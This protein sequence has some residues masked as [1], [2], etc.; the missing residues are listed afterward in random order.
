MIKNFEPRLYQ[1]TIFATATA[2]NTLVVLPTGM[3]KSI[4][5]T[6]LAAHRL[7]QYP[8][9]QILILAPTKPLAEQHI[10]TLRGFLQVAPEKIS[11][12]TGEIAPEKRK[13]L[14][15][16]STI[17]VSTPQGLE[18]D[19]VARRIDLENVSLL[20]IDECH[21]AVGDYAYVWVA[22]RYHEL[23][24]YP[25]I[26]GLTASPGDD[27]E[28]IDEV[29][30]NLFIENIELRTDEDADVS[31]YIQE[32]ST[33]WIKVELPESM[34]QV[35]SDLKTML[36]V[37]FEKLKSWGVVKRADVSYVS[38]TDILSLSSE[39]RGRA[40]RGEK[41]YVLWNALSVLAETLKIFH[42]LELIES[43][44]IAAL[45]DYVDRLNTEGA[46]TKVKAVKSIV[47]DPVFRQIYARIRL[48]KESNVVH[49][50]LLEIERI[51][52][53]EIAQD[54]KTK[55]IVFN[56]YRDSGKEIVTMINKIE[57]ASARQFVGQA[58]K[59]E[60]GLSQKKQ[61]V[62]LDDFRE[63]KFNVLVATS[64]GE[65]GID[66]PKVDVVVFYEPVPSAIRTVQRR[67]RTGRL[68]K[69]KL[70]VLITKDTRDEGIRWAAHHKEKRMH[71]LLKSFKLDKQDI[72]P[73]PEKLTSYI[74]QDKLIVYADHREK[75]SGVIK[76]LIELGVKIELDQLE[77]ADYVISKRVGIELKTVEDF[78]ASLI[79]GR[80]L[81]QL[82]HLRRS[83]QRPVI[84]I[85]GEEDLYSVRNVHKNALR[86][87]LATIAVSYGIPIV[88]TKNAKDSAGII[89]IIAKRE[90]EED[91]G[92]F[93]PH[94][95]KQHLSLK[96]HQEYVV[97]ALPGVGM[98]LAKPLLKAFKTIKNLVNASEE[99]LQNVNNIGE[100][101]AKAI[102]DVL[103]GEY[104]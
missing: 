92:E 20:T 53:E 60:S 77:V 31:P 85:E 94:S 17:V 59:A 18:N 52:K 45:Y 40:V 79:D 51:V 84:I 88:W 98:T 46:S 3:G 44:G 33:E 68:E 15:L 2:K 95:S 54:P 41:D 101:K 4:I 1:Q 13:E 37:R 21:R 25:R 30:K 66:I 81:A 90:Q 47:A 56:Q 89:Y 71:R 43:Q 93:T 99:D 6:M 34:K 102:R 28:K 9:S 104:K 96:D 36:K 58:K 62:M 65:E 72:Q 8:N 49:P 76:E 78:V 27:K 48:L 24:K 82:P 5:F 80:L 35:Q 19:I 73:S 26:L 57:N 64:V 100:K 63:S 29:C 14:W 83:Y 7:A 11:L 70:I 61:K 32:V 86:G 42:A 50:K 91:K 23:A 39:L 12:F 16:S 103:D 87:M 97:S 69:G 67:G 74:N 10:A 55:I 75:T 38:R 22:K